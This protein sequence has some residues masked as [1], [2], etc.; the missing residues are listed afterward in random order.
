[1][2][3]V[4]QEF[5]AEKIAKHVRTVYSK[6]VEALQRVGTCRMGRRLRNHRHLRLLSS[7]KIKQTVHK[8]LDV[9]N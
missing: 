2:R 8:V 7:R 1:L 6:R 9:T 5:R 4:V 3:A